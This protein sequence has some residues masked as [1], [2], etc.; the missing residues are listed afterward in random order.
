LD[1]LGLED[2]R[3][4]DQTLIHQEFKEQLQRKDDGTYS[5]GLPWRENHPFLPD[6]KAGSIARLNSQLRRLKKTPDVLLEYN[7]IMNEQIEHGIL[8]LVPKHPTGKRVF[9]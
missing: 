6:N 9:T 5:T 2:V 8:E 3:E 1:V 4:G 7:K